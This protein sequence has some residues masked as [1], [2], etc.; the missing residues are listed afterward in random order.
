M[1]APGFL[2]ADRELAITLTRLMLLSPV[3]F[4]L[5][6]IFGSILQSLE[7]FWAYAI[8]PV[9][10]NAGIIVGALYFV[11]WMKA[12]GHAEVLGLGFGVVLGALMHFIL[13]AIAA[14]MAG[15]KFKLIFDFAD[16]NF[17][18]IFKLMIPRTIGL[19]AY[20]IDSVVV[21]AIASTMAAGSIAVLNVA[22]NLQF[23]PIAVVGVAAATAVFPR[24]SMHASSQEKKE[25]EQKLNSALRTTALIVTPLAV[26]G[27]FLSHWAINLL[28]GVGLFRG[29]SIDLTASVLMIFMFGVVAQSLIPILSRAF[30][31]MHNTKIPV[32]V[33][34][35]SIIINLSLAWLM[36]FHF[37][38]DVRGLA[39]AFAVAGNIN[40]LL[41][42][43][44]FKRF[45][46]SSNLLQ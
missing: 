23:V 35:F 36:T 22:N 42:W 8:A 19:G 39:I 24:L 11:P 3:L 30:Y 33:S 2:G 10:Y 43:I 21:N 41:L 16:Q 26:A 25:F 32:T 28:F 40:F 46:K 4:S 13:Q 14:K 15:F 20:S 45:T 37:H 9:L 29:T 1:I 38:A 12:H 17:R 27:I 31:A 6:T 5:S 44:F 7:R 34:I 18:K